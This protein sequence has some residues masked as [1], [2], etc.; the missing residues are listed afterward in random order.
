[1]TPESSTVDVVERI[2]RGERSAEEELVRSF[3]RPVYAM[4]LART[5]DPEAAQDL[6]Q[7]TL[8]AVLRSLREGKLHNPQGLV[9]FICGT[10][11]NRLKHH[12]RSLHLER[13]GDLRD[14]PAITDLNPEQAFA[15]AER[16]ALANQAIAALGTIDQKIL[17]LTL[18]EGLAPRQIGKQLGLSSEVVR[19]R[20]SR[21]IRAAREM[22]R[23]KL[24][25]K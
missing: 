2:G 11:R 23:D 14:E 20:K 8:L 24:S 3:Y 4:V 10:M 19:Q 6:T 1:M 9:G 21:A 16:E 12:F 25:R 7:E 18:V 13:R 15:T 22:L 5:G 17:R